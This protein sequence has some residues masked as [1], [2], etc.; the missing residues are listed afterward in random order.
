M[1]RSVLSDIL[2]LQP[3]LAVVLCGALATAC[4][5]P[6]PEPEPEPA[7]IDDLT[8]EMVNL[9]QPFDTST[10]QIFVLRVQ[11]EFRLI[12]C[13]PDGPIAG[14]YEDVL[15]VSGDSIAWNAWLD[16]EQVP[17]LRVAFV[18]P[19]AVAVVRDDQPTATPQAK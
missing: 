17:G 2:S 8:A 10:G 7:P 19:S 5:S 13:I 15:S 1:R 14:C 12:R 4:A 9:G 11:D 3:V 16:V 6:P 18:S